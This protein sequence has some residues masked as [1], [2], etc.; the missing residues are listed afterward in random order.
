MKISLTIYLFV[1]L[2]LNFASACW[3]FNNL[4]GDN[5]A[6]TG[7][8]I[9]N[10]IS[11][12]VLDGSKD[13]IT[14]ENSNNE[15]TQLWFVRHTQAGRAYIINKDTE[16]LL[17]TTLLILSN[18][19]FFFRRALVPQSMTSSSVVTTADVSNETLLQQWYIQKDGTI[20]NAVVNYVLDISDGNLVAGET[21]IIYS[22]RN[23]S[24]N[25]IFD[26][27]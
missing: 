26:F 2:G 1:C 14:V 18:N 11:G 25:Q 7:Q 23:S 24:T 9:R 4:F 15:D 16:Y 12:L 22:Q 3:P 21:L 19:M 8:I 5:C 10:P 13:V 6:V 17:K 20:A 27:V